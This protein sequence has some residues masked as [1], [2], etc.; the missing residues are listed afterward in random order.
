MRPSV[1]PSGVME[2]RLRKKKTSGGEEREE[3]GAIFSLIHFFTRERDASLRSLAC[4]LRM[5][6]RKTTPHFFTLA[7]TI[8][9]PLL[10]LPKRCKK[11]S[12]GRSSPLSL[13]SSFS[14]LQ[15]RYTEIEPFSP[16]LNC[17]LGFCASVAGKGRKSRI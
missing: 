1:C 6:R 17:H 3:T 12:A 7:S 16:P 9:L 5:T 13:S 2:R 8:F 10:F 11:G 4:L 14:F 15:L